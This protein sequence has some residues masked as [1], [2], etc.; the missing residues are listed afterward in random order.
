M[1]TT[2]LKALAVALV[3]E[4]LRDEPDPEQIRDLLSTVAVGDLGTLVALVAVVAAHV[5]SP[6]AE[7]R[8]QTLGLIVAGGEPGQHHD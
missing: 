7:R 6:A 3:T 5:A 1:V 4:A 2:D 8:L